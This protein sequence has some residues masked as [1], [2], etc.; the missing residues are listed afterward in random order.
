VLEPTQLPPDVVA[1]LYA[2]RWQI[3]TAFHLVKRLLGLAYLWTGA[4]NGVK[5]QIW[6]TWLFYA[7]LMD[8]ADAVANELEV[9][10]ESI[11]VELLFRGLYHFHQAHSR[12]QAT[13]PIAYFAA[14]ENA[15]LDLVKAIPQS[16][17]KP[18]LD[19]S[20]YPDLTLVAEP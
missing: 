15:D 19:L 11:S 18:P 7:V 2:R 9:P 17:R 12:G 10:T 8:L 6:A 3:E 1:D 14:P 20:P 5:L 4:L 16:R 13:D